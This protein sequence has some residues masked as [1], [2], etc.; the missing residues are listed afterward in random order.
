VI[1]HGGKITSGRKES[2]LGAVRAVFVAIAFAV[3]AVPTN[4]SAGRTFYGWL[5]GHEVVPEKSVEVQQWVYERNGIGGAA[6]I[7]DTALWWGA[8]VGITDQLE[9]VLPIEFLSRE[10]AAGSAGFVVEKFGVEARYRFTKHDLEKPDGIAPLLRVAVKRDV[11]DRDAVL[12]ET[13]FV[14]AYQAG[15]FHGQ[16]DLGAVARISKD[17]TKFELRP[18]AGVS[19][20]TKKGLRFGAEAFFEIFADR[21]LKKG[22][23]AGVG[24][25]MVWTTGRFWVTASLLIG[26]YQ[27]ETAPR[28]IWGVLF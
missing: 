21:D 20:E 15:R 22:D 28:V 16:I 23:W 3:L 26:V 27:I 12:T 13:D 17:T 7:H 2:K 8:L 19:I 4:A 9:L 1:D 10:S 11:L 18:G 24:P 14:L 5:Y 25:N 6:D